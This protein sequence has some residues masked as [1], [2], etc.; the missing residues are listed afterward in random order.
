MGQN[1]EGED[2]C[3]R[4]NH[5]HKNTLGKIHL[6][7]ERTKPGK[8]GFT[9]ET[10]NRAE[11]A[12]LSIFFEKLHP[13]PRRAGAGGGSDRQWRNADLPAMMPVYGC[14]GAVGC[15]E[16]LESAEPVRYDAVL[17]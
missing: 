11:N 9:L 5:M 14:L 7:G 16:A 12:L 2:S 15:G 10:S 6:W 17:I 8:H 4:R 1:T 3:E 13:G